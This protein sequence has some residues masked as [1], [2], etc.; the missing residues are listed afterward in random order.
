MKLTDDQKALALE[1]YLPAAVPVYAINVLNEDGSISRTIY[2]DTTTGE[3][4]V[5]AAGGTL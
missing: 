3:T 5:E 4:V 2:V 1:T